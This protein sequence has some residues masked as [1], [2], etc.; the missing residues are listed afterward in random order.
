MIEIRH[1]KLIDIVSK[2]GSLK[3][4]ADELC[5]TQS[6]LSHQLKE[7]ESELGTP[8]FHRTNNRLHFTPVGKELLEAGKEILDKLQLLENKVQQIAQDQLKK[9]IHGY[10]TE[11]TKRLN[12]QATSIAELLHWDSKWEAGSL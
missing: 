7:L 6:A 5:L 2:V 8:V 9:Y 11:E 10:S 3:K 12:D 1:F 4:A